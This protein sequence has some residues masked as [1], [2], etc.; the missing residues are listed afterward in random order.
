MLGAVRITDEVEVRAALTLPASRA[1]GAQPWRLGAHSS[2]S[3]RLAE[4][5]LRTPQLI[6]LSTGP[7]ADLGLRFELRQQLG[8]P[9]PARVRRRRALSRPSTAG[10]AGGPAWRSPPK[11]GRP[12]RSR[13]CRSSGR[14]SGG[15]S[16]STLRPKRLPRA[17]GPCP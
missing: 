3:A 6:K 10:P 15:C 13:G 5:R 1:V 4:D 8:C 9:A 17:R 11:L 7:A 14:R 12:R 16:G 2:T